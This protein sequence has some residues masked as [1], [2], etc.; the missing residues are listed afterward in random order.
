MFASKTIVE[1][2]VRGVAGIGLFV[3]AVLVSA[4]HPFVALIAASLALVF[5]RGCPM[6]W[7][8]GLFETIAAK[9]SGRRT[10]SACADGGCAS[11]RENESHDRSPR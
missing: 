11:G 9:I 10:P 8:I 5:L 2:V 4:S 6:C 3:A 1:H 7:T